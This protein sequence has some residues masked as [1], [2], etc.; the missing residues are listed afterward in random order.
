MHRRQ[1]LSV[2]CFRS[3]D[4]RLPAMPFAFYDLETTGTSPA[5]DQPLQF[6]AILADD[7]LRPLERV[8]MRCR[9]A[10]HVLPSPV[11]LAISGVQIDQLTDPALPSWFE[12]MQEIQ[13]LVEAWAPAT[14]TG[15]NSM[16]FDENFLRQSFYQMLQPSV[17]ATQFNGNTRLDVLQVLYA[18]HWR[19]HKTLAWPVENAG[20]AVFRLDALAP[21]NGFKDHDAHDALGDV[22]ATLHLLQLVRS[23]APDLFEEIL[24]NRDKTHVDRLLASGEPLEFVTRLSAAPPRGIV[25]CGSGHDAESANAAA[26]FDVRIADP[27]ECFSLDQ[28]GL[29]ELL[30]RS[31]RVVHRLKINESP[32]LFHSRVVDETV[33][34]RCREIASSPDF[35]R[36]VGTAM[37][38]LRV[39]R[40][41]P[42]SPGESVR[43]EERIYDGFYGREDKRLLRSFN[44]ADDWQARMSVVEQ[45]GDA[46]LQQL[47]RRATVLM[48]PEIMPAAAVASA[49]RNILTRWRGTEAPPNG[50]T[51]IAAVHA[52]IDRLLREGR[53]DDGR[54]GNLRNFYEA[55]VRTLEANQMP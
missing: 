39:Q 45:F 5:Y 49:T 34:D 20:N 3:M 40:Y 26:F 25:G 11:A 43:V 32:M 42:P 8:N 16:S 22:E 46:R 31:P 7:E 41:P 37:A 35:S 52:Q 36:R 23:R 15:Y 47:G 6:A 4:R 33:R 38:E 53:I 24:D 13:R 27:V 17:F 48:A 10:P 30:D 29:I 9:L 12:M 18:V 51:T 44:M 19:A 54:A 28:A 55:R 2:F 50:W 1:G 14:W 21:A